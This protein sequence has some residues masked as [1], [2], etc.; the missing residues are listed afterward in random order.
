MRNNGYLKGPKSFGGEGYESTR[1]NQLYIRR[2]IVRENMESNTSYYLRFKDVNGGF[3]NL[4]YLEIVPESVYD[5]T[6]SKED[7]W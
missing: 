5:G 4:D 6:D 3:I 2:I 1:N 7:I